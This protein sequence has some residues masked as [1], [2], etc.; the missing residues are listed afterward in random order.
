MCVYIYI[1][2]SVIFY[3]WTYTF[4]DINKCTF[5]AKGSFVISFICEEI[6]L[7]Q[8]TVCVTTLPLTLWPLSLFPWG[9]V[10]SQRDGVCDGAGGSAGSNP[11]RNRTLLQLLWIRP[12]EFLFF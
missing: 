1:F 10:S 7:C 8:T 6:K 3:S 12:Q 9:W 11:R 2:P 4:P 5:S